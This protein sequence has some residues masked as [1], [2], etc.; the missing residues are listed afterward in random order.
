MTMAS[1]RTHST[2]LKQLKLEYERAT[3]KERQ[4]HITADGQPSVT[5][6][7]CR[8]LSVFHGQM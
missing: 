2:K 8:E 6:H 4:I 7:W 1:F 3:T 5:M